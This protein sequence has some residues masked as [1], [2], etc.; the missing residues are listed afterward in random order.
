[1]NTQVVLP[2]FGTFRIHLIP[3]AFM[4]LLAQVLTSSWTRTILVCIDLESI[5]LHFKIF[6]QQEVVVGLKNHLSY[7][8]WWPNPQSKD[9]IKKKLVFLSWL[10]SI[11]TGAA[12]GEAFRLWPLLLSCSLGFFMSV[13]L[14]RWCVCAPRS[15]NIPWG[16]TSSPAQLIH[17]M[18]PLCNKPSFLSPYPSLLLA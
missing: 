3:P 16:C 15:E 13:C 6:W 8:S 9:R 2:T 11:G 4:Y 14:L 5:F 1:M 17:G 10:T 18:S 12:C 7:V